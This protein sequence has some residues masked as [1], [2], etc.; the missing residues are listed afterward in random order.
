MLFT[1]SEAAE[2][3]RICV[4]QLDAVTK[5][6]DLPR[7]KFGGEGRARARVMYRRQDLLNY[8]DAHVVP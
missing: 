3:L 1:R 4:S 7:V 5:R 8:I 2:F 6:A